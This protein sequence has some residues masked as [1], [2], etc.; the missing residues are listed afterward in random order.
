MFEDGDGDGKLL[1]K[2]SEE[3]KQRIQVL[4]ESMGTEASLAVGVAC[5]NLFKLP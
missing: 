3:K 2:S 5:L 4:S 1:K